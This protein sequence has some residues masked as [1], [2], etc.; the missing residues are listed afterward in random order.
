VTLLLVS[1]NAIYD[2]KV[3]KILNVITKISWSAVAFTI[4]PCIICFKIK[5]SPPVELC[6][7]KKR[8]P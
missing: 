7:Q 1:E 2:T 3:E 4:H 5:D 8:N 6:W